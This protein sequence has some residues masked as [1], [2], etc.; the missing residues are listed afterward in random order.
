MTAVL[1]VLLAALGGIV[2]VKVHDAAG[3][4]MMLTGFALVLYWA[5]LD[6]LAGDLW[7]WMRRS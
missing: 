6:G 7:R 2:A 3:A 5:Y 1:G 4:V